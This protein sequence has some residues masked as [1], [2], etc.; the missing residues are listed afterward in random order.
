MSRHVVSNLL[1][2]FDSYYQTVLNEILFQCMKTEQVTCNRMLKCNI[3]CILIVQDLG[4]T[5]G[6]TV[7]I[8]PL[9]ALLPTKDHP[10]PAT[11]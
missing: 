7:S 2:N 3:N 1:N 6:C 10:P 9:A 5:F 11:H 4:T 8:T